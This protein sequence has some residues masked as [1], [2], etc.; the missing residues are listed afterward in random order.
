MAL[1]CQVKESQ[2]QPVQDIC[3]CCSMIWLNMNLQCKTAI[4][5]EKGGKN[6][7]LELAGMKLDVTD[8]G[9]ITVFYKYGILW[10]FCRKLQQNDFSSS[11]FNHNLSKSVVKNRC[12]KIMKIGQLIEQGVLLHIYVDPRT[13]HTGGRKH[14]SRTQRDC[15]LCSVRTEEQSDGELFEADRVQKR[16]VQGGLRAEVWRQPVR[17]RACAVAR[18]LIRMFRVRTMHYIESRNCS[19]VPYS[20]SVRKRFN[21]SSQLVGWTDLAVFL[22]MIKIIFHYSNNIWLESQ[23]QGIRRPW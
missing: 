14:R 7:T 20:R 11:H 19:K 10:I 16:A 18:S 23:K 9:T 3:S 17:T 5:Y 6:N 2:D 4:F 13:M 8:N 12:A 1:S 15:T 21:V 22:D